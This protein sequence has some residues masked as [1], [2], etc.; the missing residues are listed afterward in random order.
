MYKLYAVRERHPSVNITDR[1]HLHH[2]F[3]VSILLG[4]SLSF[5]ILILNLVNICRANRQ[6]ATELRNEAARCRELAERKRQMVEEKES[7]SMEWHE[8]AVREEEVIASKDLIKTII[9]K[10]FNC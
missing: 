5:F 9:F 2:E 7:E 1:Q 4:L 8:R 6:R 10:I 3:W